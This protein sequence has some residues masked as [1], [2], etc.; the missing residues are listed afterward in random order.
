MW[1]IDPCLLANC[2]ALRMPQKG[3]VA[4]LG[5]ST[6]FWPDL[7]LPVA[8]ASPI[9]V[10]SKNNKPELFHR[11]QFH[12]SCYQFLPPTFTSSLAIFPPLVF[13]YKC[14]FFMLFQFKLKFAGSVWSSKVETFT[15]CRFH[16]SPCFVC[17]LLF[18]SFGFH[19]T[20]RPLQ[21]LPFLLALCGVCHL[22]AVLIKSFNTLIALKIRE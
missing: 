17:F 21:F 12:F 11:C 5:P 22:T 1:A 16:P 15:L 10:N 6:P 18:C 14:A 3:M 2:R 7:E 9:S 8:I 4:I 20:P 13:A 19:R